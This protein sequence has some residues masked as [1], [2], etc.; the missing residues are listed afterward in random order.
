LFN[1]EPFHASVSD[2]IT[3]ETEKLEVYF[4]FLQDLKSS[5]I[6]SEE[7]FQLQDVIVGMENGFTKFNEIAEKEEEVVVSR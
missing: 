5:R 3:I 7:Y 4:H 2:V 6:F 1:A